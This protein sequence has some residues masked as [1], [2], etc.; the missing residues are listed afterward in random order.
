MADEI[1]LTW[2]LKVD[3]ASA[4]IA[5]DEEKSLTIDMAG[6]HQYENVQDIGFASHEA[7]A[8][9]SDMANKGIVVVENLD[10]TNY[11]TLGLD[12]TGSFVYPIKLL[13]GE[14]Y[15]FRSQEGASWYAQANTAAC[16]LRVRVFEL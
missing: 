10:A 6:T 12:V 7:I 16:K 1:T 3:K 4:G 11:I 15:V 14:A 2:R 5:Y 8:F 13:P 9:P